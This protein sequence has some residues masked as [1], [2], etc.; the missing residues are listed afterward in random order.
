M[1]QSCCKVSCFLNIVF[2]LHLNIHCIKHKILYFQRKRKTRFYWIP[3]SQD[4]YPRSC[5][6]LDVLYTLEM[7]GIEFLKWD[8]ELSA[9]ANKLENN[10]N[11]KIAQD[12]RIPARNVLRW[13]CALLPWLHSSIYVSFSNSPSVVCK[14]LAPNSLPGSCRQSDI[15]PFLIL[16]LQ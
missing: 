9:I 12:V 5:M 3:S 4:I 6:A 1:L 16:L 2:F 8:A 13:F 10:F 11:R 15:L 14:S 7:L